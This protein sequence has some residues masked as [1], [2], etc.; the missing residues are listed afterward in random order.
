MGNSTKKHIAL[1][2]LESIQPLVFLSKLLE[3]NVID[4]SSHTKE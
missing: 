2:V 1:A 4:K 3:I